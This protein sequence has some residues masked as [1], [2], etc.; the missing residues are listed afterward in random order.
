[1]STF[2]L[3]LPIESAEE[4][5]VL[6]PVEPCPANDERF[7][8]WSAPFV[9]RHA[10]S[11][12]RVDS[13]FQGQKALHFCFEIRTPEDVWMTGWHLWYDAAIVT[14]DDVP[15][16]ATCQ[17]S[18]AF[19]E[20][21][22]GYGSDNNVHVRPWVGLVARMQDVRQYYFLCL[23][24]PDALTLYRRE[25][26]QWLVVARRQVEVNVWTPY[27]LRLD[28][29]D[30]MF[31]AWL[32]GQRMFTATDYA[33]STGQAG[34]R[35]SCT[36]FAWD[37]SI[38]A[39]PPAAQAH[40]EL[41][42]RRA[43]D[44]A[45]ARGALPEPEL[46]KTL[47]LDELGKVTDVRFAH[48]TGPGRPMTCLLALDG[49]ADGATHAVT[50]L[51]GKVLWLA[52]LPGLR[53]WI[54]TEPRD[55]GH[56]DIFGFT[57][58]ELVLADGRT[59]EVLARRP[60][61]SLPTPPAKPMSFLP[62]DPV[63][64]RGSGARDG[65]LLIEGANDRHLWA[66]DGELNPLWVVETP[67]GLGHG[68]HVSCCDVDGDGREEVF[69]GGVLV[70]GDGRIV[71]RQEHLLSR[72]LAPNAGHVDSSQMGY[73]AGPDAAPTVH[74]QSSSGGHVVADARTGNLLASHPQGHV[75]GGC[76]G[77]FVPGE[78]GVQ[79]AAANRWGNYGLLGVYA[80]AGRR[81]GRFQ[82]DY[83]CDHPVAVNWTADGSELILIAG[84]PRAVGLYDAAGR[85]VVDLA[86]LCPTD[87][88][89]VLRGKQGTR[90]AARLTDDPRDVVIL[91]G[92]NR[93]H[94]IRP[95]GPL[96]ARDR[97]YTPVR[98]WDVSWPAWTD[99]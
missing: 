74:M 59:G 11:L 25:D 7:A 40:I 10:R 14:T 63:D 93:M 68:S 23:E 87:E 52:E 13:R 34:L 43:N 41:C 5:Y 75:Q 18:V 84:E 49:R 12:M 47:E 8:D 71:W 60:L 64:L 38:Q 4:G 51:D 66:V 77:A 29:R 72:L 50:D 55:D 91:R 35:A 37:V 67:S 82:P 53:R 3:S 36:S 96:P 61:D 58:T 28:M 48:W 62:S 2:E 24:Y 57:K 88:R 80:G 89:F 16:D 98:R 65:F 33:Y 78:P 6:C 31:T 42:N 21:T 9:W 20:V 83:E 26:D 69:A 94:L 85:R 79:V 30:A 1:M 45:E 70:D 81:L 17:A 46:W 90:S 39:D 54:A 97:H 86:S 76:G 56:Q 32:D 95:A 73:L 44:L 15:A 22:T 27:T 99:A 92:H 19:E